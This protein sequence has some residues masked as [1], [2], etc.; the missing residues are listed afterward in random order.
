MS[1]VTENPVEAS[2]CCAEGISGAV[3]KAR[4]AFA[5][6]RETIIH[7]A[8]VE[9]ARAGVRAVDDYVH[10]SPWSLIGGV[11]VIALAVGLLLRRR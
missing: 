5:G 11:A 8:P 9:K 4:A 10:K 2:K 6:A 1:N 7:A 3:D